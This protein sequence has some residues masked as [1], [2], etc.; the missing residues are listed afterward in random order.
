M[1]I[2]RRRINKIDPRQKVLY[3]AGANYF[4]HAVKPAIMIPMHTMGQGDL[5]QDYARHTH[6]RNCRVVALTERGQQCSYDNQK[7]ETQ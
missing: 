4:F 1:T 7:E 5:A 6:M 3:E 2:K